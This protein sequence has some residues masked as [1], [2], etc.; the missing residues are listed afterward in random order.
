MYH[1]VVGNH[2]GES[3]TCQ[4]QIAGEEEF[5]DV[6]HPLQVSSCQDGPQS[7]LLGLFV[8]SRTKEYRPYPWP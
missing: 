3:G 1:H 6:A 5:R 7:R 4:G 2:V 8:P